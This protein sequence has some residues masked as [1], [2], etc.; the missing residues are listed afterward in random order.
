[1]PWE[2]E[3]TGRLFL[4]MLR[5]EEST[6]GQ[7]QRERQKGKASLSA[8]GVKGMW[9]S[10]AKGAERQPALPVRVFYYTYYI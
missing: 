10:A 2:R 4:P 7:G 9:Q 5:P 8:N 1:M 3:G 6:R